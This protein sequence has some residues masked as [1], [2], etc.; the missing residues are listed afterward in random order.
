MWQ[1]IVVSLSNKLESMW[2]VAFM[3][4]F[5][6]ILHYFHGKTEGRHKTLFRMADL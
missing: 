5:K 2:N 1:I 6:V 4:K 3:D